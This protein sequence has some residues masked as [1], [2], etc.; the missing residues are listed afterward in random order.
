M[1]AALRARV[2][3]VVNW[4][5]MARLGGAVRW[6]LVETPAARRAGKLV[7]EHCRSCLGSSQ[8]RADA[9][10]QL[11]RGLALLLLALREQ[12]PRA[13]DLSRNCPS[14]QQE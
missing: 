14:T 10:H 9:L 1:R 4:F 13:R 8:Q 2:C 12:R 5:C 11:F 6:H 3:V 7:I